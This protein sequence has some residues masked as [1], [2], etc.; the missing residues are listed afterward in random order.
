MVSLQ[1][2]I[3]EQRE[4]NSKRRMLLVLDLLFLQSTPP[5]CLPQNFI[6]QINT[7]LLSPS[8]ILRSSL[9]SAFHNFLPKTSF[10]DYHWEKELP[11]EIYMIFEFN[12]F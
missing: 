8:L 4:Y 9:F 2:K 5:R 11:N 6:I 3:M 7:I 1:I 12:F 10:T